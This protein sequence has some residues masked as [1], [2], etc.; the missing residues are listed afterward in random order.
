MAFSGF[1][2]AAFEFFAGLREH[3]EPGWFKPRKALY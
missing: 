1:P 2:A 3:N